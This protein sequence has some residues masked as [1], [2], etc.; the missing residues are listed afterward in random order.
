MP[1]DQLV[2]HVVAHIADDCRDVGGAHELDA[3]L[4]DGLALVVDDVV[5]LQEV[6]ADLEVALF[7]APL[8]GFERLVHPRVNNGFPFL[9]AEPTHDCVEPVGGED[10]QKIVFQADIEFRLAGIALAAGTAAQLIVDAPAFMALG[11]EHIEPA[12]I[13]RAFL[14]GFDIGDDLPTE[15]GDLVRRL[16]PFERRLEAH[17][18]VAAQLNVGAAAGHVGGDGDRARHAGLRDDGGFLFVV[19]RVQHLVRDAALFQEARQIFRLLDRDRADQHGL[20]ATVRLFDV[21]DDGFVFLFRGPIDLVVD[22]DALDFAVGRDFNHVELVD[23]AEFG[24]FR[25]GGAGHAGELVIEAEVVLECDR[26]QRLVFRLD[27]DAFLG[28]DRLVEAFGQA[29]AMHHAASEFIDQNDFVVLNDVV[30]VALEQLVR[31]QRLISVVHQ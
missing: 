10:A 22:I 6:L 31:A 15:R 18:N 7:N 20:A 5:V 26:R 9:N 30:L 27:V 11:A 16:I 17:L 2:H 21:G 25:G 19:T 14:L 8:T 4:E 13:K 1:P 28:F 24:G 29:P 3:L 23:I 12:R